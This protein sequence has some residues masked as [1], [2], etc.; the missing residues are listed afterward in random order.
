M[1]DRLSTVSRFPL[2]APVAVAAVALLVVVTQS[3]WMNPEPQQE[4]S[5]S[6][7]MR[8]TLR[9]TASEAR[10]WQQPG[11]RSQG[12]EEADII[13]TLKRGARVDVVGEKDQWY[14]VVLPDGKEGWMERHAFE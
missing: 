6:I 11:A 10:V 13:A 2:L 4:R 3:N 1:L 9:V 8:E 14:Q 12:S 5:R 7:A